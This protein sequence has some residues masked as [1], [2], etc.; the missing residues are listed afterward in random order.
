MKNNLLKLFSLLLVAILCFSIVS[1]NKKKDED[2]MWKD[3]TYT[4]D[5]TVGEEESSSD[6]G[7]TIGEGKKTVTVEIIAGEHTVTLTVKTDKDNLGAALYEYGIINDPVFFDTCNGMKADWE[8]D[9]AYWAFK[10]NGEM[11]NYGVGDAKIYGGEKF[12]IEYTK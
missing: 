8:K 2:E 9:Q 7:N 3:A 11:L 6:N 1:C 5:A 12:T 4:S 10:Q